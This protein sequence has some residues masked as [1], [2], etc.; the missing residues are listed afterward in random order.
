VTEIL[1]DPNPSILAQSGTGTIPNPRGG[2]LYI[3]TNQNDD[4]T[5][6]ENEIK[7][8]TIA[9]E[10][11]LG[12]W[13][14]NHRFAGLAEN[15]VQDRH[16]RSRREILV[17]QFNRPITNATPENAQNLVYRRTYVTEGDF[18]TYAHTGLYTPLAPFTYNGLTVGP[19][20][21]NTGELIS[22]KDVESLM[23]A[24]Q[25]SWLN[26]KL[27]TT[28]GWRQDNIVYLDTTS[29]RVAAG[30]PRIASGERLVNEV[31][32]LPGFDR[33]KIKADTLT[34]GGVLHL[35]KRLSVFYNQSTNTGVPRFNRRI[36]PTGS[37]PGTPEGEGRDMGVMIDLLGDDRFFAR[38]TYFET[39][40]VGDA[41]V[42]P[43]G[44]VTNAQAL[45][46]SQTLAV[47]AAFRDAGRISQADYDAQSFNWNA[48][49]IDTESEG[50]E[51]ELVANPTP[52]WTIRANYSHSARDRTNFF[53][54]GK[55]FFT[56]KFPEW[57]ALAG[58][59]PVLSALVETSINEIQTE[60]IDERAAGLEQGFGSIPHKATLTTRYKFSQGRARGAFVGGAMRYQS[61]AFS[62]TDTRDPS[63]GGTGK[64]YFTHSTL[65]TDAFVG[66]RFKMP[67]R[68]LPA[69]VQL[70]GR[71]IFNSDLVSLARY[72]ADFSGPRRIYLREPRSWRL[73]LSM[74]Y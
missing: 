67:W 60:E 5:D 49:I 32:A 14:G 53:A 68:N 9:Y 74:E 55:A 6:T 36:L 62:Q 3:E 65:F 7:R 10:L 63:V 38:I 18:S 4:R 31:T 59:D 30:D 35:H 24:A 39:N 12:K 28:L 50:V 40:Q 71:N 57:R 26:G 72:N 25:S 23:L 51:L 21:I 13:F 61:G 15:A 34:A 43:S 16:T 29:G 42:S 56:Q 2:Q 58:N 52:N 73:T 37:I 69:S 11:K 27:A 44:A 66:Y 33:N 19:R 64:D 54:E 47:L 8:L 20:M 1:G 22:V 41:A 46:R 70:N 45:G 48:A 17:D